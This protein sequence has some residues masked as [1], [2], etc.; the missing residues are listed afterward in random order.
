MTMHTLLESWCVVFDALLAI[1]LLIAIGVLFTVFKF[2][3][4]L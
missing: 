4:C 2:L 3:L 1:A